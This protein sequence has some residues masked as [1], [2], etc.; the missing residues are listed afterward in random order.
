M[1]QKEPPSKADATYMGLLQELQGSNPPW[2]TYNQDLVGC[3]GHIVSTLNHKDHRIFGSILGSH[4]QAT[5]PGV[6]HWRERDMGGPIA[7][8]LPVFQNWGGT[9]LRTIVF[10]GLYWSP[11]FSKSTPHYL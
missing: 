1:K 11:M 9:L 8:I 10:W 5:E 2:L 7:R 4:A 6:S 3:Q